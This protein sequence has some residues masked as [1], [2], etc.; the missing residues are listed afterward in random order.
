MVWQDRR[1]AEGRE[2]SDLYG[3]VSTDGGASFIPE[4]RVSSET[5]C[6]GDYEENGAAAARF[7]LGGGDYQGLAATGPGTFQAVWSDSRTGRYQLW[8]AWLQVQQE[9]DGQTTVP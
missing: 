9:T 5:V 1:N 7:R 8:T 6:P 4:V 3:A 2:C